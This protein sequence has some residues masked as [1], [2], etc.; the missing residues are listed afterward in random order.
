M[1][2][3]AGR[4]GGRDAYQPP[5]G[6]E[7]EREKGNLDPVRRRHAGSDSVLLQPADR[8]RALRGRCRPRNH[9]GVRAVRRFGAAARLRRRLAARTGRRPEQTERCDVHRFARRRLSAAGHAPPD[10]PV[11]RRRS[12]LRLII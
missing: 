6:P 2:F 1:Q 3:R 10:R 11:R 4:N 12:R 9:A 7:P 5:A 8:R